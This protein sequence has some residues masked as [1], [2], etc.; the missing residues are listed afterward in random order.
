[1]ARFWRFLGPGGYRVEVATAGD[2]TVEE[3]M[4]PAPEI[5]RGTFMKVIDENKLAVFVD[6]DSYDRVVEVP[7]I[8]KKDRHQR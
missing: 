1:M 5:G 4:L 2:K 7:Y 6:T 8:D 3:H